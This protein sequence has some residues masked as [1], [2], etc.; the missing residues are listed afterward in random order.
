MKLVIVMR[1]DLNMRKG[2]MVAQGAHA[3]IFPFLFATDDPND[4]AAR[5]LVQWLNCG[6]KKICVRADSL[7]ELDAIELQARSAG[8]EVYVVNDAGHTEFHGV[9]TKT[10]I[11]IGP[12]EEDKI[13][14]ITGGL[15]LL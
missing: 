10:C 15:R 5:R 4:Q 1:T 2:K 13:D 3:A 14:R 6:M 12:D 7:A 9:T 11:S 8:V